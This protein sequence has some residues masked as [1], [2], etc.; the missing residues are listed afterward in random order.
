VSR[1]DQRRLVAAGLVSTCRGISGEELSG[2][3]SDRVPGHLVG[4]AD[5]VERW[6]IGEMLRGLDLRAAVR[7]AD[8]TSW[9]EQVRGEDDERAVWWAGQVCTD[10]SGELVEVPAEWDVAELDG[11]RAESLG[12]CCESPTAPVVPTPAGGDVPVW[13][14]EWLGRLVYGPKR[15]LLAGLVAW[16]WHGGARPAVPSAPWAVKLADRFDR[17]VGSREVVA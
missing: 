10:E 6:V 1:R 12:V 7:R 11:W 16:R 4:D 8:V 17:R 2:P 3:L 5:G 15:D 14:A 13:V 9:H